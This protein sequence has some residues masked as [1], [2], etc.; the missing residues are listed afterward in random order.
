MLSKTQIVLPAHVFLIVC[1]NIAVCA[2][3]KRMVGVPRASAS[4]VVAILPAELHGR[5][6]DLIRLDPTYRGSELSSGNAE[7]YRWAFLRATQPRSASMPL[8]TRSLERIV[9]VIRRI[10]DQ[11]I[12]ESPIVPDKDAARQWIR[13]QE[14]DVVRFVER[15]LQRLRADPLF[16]GCKRLLTAD[17]AIKVVEDVASVQVP[18]LHAPRQHDPGDWQDELRH[19]YTKKLPNYMVFSISLI[20][21]QEEVLRDYSP[22]HWK[23]EWFGMSS[24]WPWVL[25]LTPIHQAL[26]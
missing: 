11:R 19:F 23:V 25:S 15:S 16:P 26:R 20:S 10:V 1:V 18:R 9:E 6:W 2:D 22:E 14:P 8:S 24:A 21:C 5:A 17:E 7:G 4:T 3:G 12:D 13:D